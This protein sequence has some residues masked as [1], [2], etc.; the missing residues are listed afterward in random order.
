MISQTAGMLAE[1]GDSA[2]YTNFATAV[3][4]LQ[5]NVVTGDEPWLDF[6]KPNKKMLNKQ[7]A[8]ICH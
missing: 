1:E 5:A 7:C 8:T 4:K 3:S 2:L 6:F